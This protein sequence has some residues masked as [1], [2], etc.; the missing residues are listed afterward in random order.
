MPTQVSRNAF[1]KFA[2]V[3]LGSGGVLA[4][5]CSSTDS[6]SGEADAGSSGTSGR[7]S[8]TSGGASGASGTSGTSGT[9]GASGT[10]GTSGASGTSGTSGTSGASGTSG[11]SGTDSG[12]DTGTDAPVSACSANGAKHSVITSNHGHALLIPAADFVTPA[13]GT[14]DIKGGGTHAHSLALT[15]AQLTSLMNG[16]SVTVTS[17]IGNGHTHD[18]TVICA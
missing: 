7:A 13:A 18:V 8:G 10:S 6:S 12:T 5:A 15:A 2:V 1:L 16:T 9:S 17:G 14:Y 3:F 4:T 11:T